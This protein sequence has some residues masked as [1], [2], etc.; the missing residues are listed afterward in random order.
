MITIEEAKQLG[1]VEN[2]HVFCYTY[3]VGELELVVGTDYICLMS[4]QDR[5][6]VDLSPLTAEQVKQ[7]ITLLKP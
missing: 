4:P 3:P 1:F 6:S 2:E 5:Q 7:L